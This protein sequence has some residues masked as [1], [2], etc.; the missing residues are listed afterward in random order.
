MEKPKLVLTR[1]DWYHNCGDGCCFDFGA[2]LYINDERVEGV[3]LSD[4]SPEDALEAV[5][6][7]LGYEV[8]WDEGSDD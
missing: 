1:E 5:L 2:D 3:D 7:H 8:V 4:E 6:E